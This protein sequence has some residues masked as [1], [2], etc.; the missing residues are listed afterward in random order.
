MIIALYDRYQCLK[1]RL[2]KSHT[3]SI[4]YAQGQTH[5]I[6]LL[7]EKTYTK[8]GHLKLV[9]EDPTGFLTCIITQQ[10]PQ[11]NLA[12]QLPLDC[13]LAV[14]GNVKEGTCFVQHLFM[15]SLHQKKIADV[16]MYCR[17]HN[18]MLEVHY[19]D[20]M[21]NIPH[22]KQ[23]LTRYEPYVHE[24]HVSPTITS[25]IVLYNRVLDDALSVEM[26]LMCSHLHPCHPQRDGIQDALLLRTAPKIL[27]VRSTQN[28]VTYVHNIVCVEV[29]SEVKV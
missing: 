21:Y 9:I 2:V 5:C 12:Q 18:D 28:A 16:H 19:Q 24:Q 29:A 17:V 20:T 25:D 3:V 11:F 4:A 23:S 15:P 6:G 13:V 26:I 22:Q 10:M 14:Q 1:Q 7:Y 8:N 27:V